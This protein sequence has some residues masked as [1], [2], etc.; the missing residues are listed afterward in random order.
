MWTIDIGGS[1]YPVN[2]NHISTELNG[3]EEAFF[4][5]ENN[6]IRRSLVDQDKDVTIKF[7]GKQ[8][9][10]GTLAAVEYTERNLKCK[11]Y[12][13]VYNLM[14]KKEHTQTYADPGT[15][16]NTILGN[17]CGEVAG[18]SAGSSPADVVA[19]RYSRTGCLDAA[20]YLTQT[21]VKDFWSSGGDTFNIGTRG[22]NKG[23][24]VILS[25]SRRTINRAKKRSI[26]YVRGQDE[27]GNAIEGTYGAGTY[28]VSFTER[29]ATNVATL[30]NIAE[31]KYNQLNKDSSGVKLTSPIE[32]AYDLHPGDTVV[33]DKPELNLSGSYRIWRI[34][35]KA[36]V[37]EIEIDKQEELLER[38]LERQR[39]LEDVGIYPAPG[40]NLDLP[41]GAPA[42]PT[43]LTASNDV[44]LS[45]D[46]DW[47][48]NTETD[49]SQ[50][51][52][53]R[54]SVDSS[55]GSAL[56]AK[57]NS[58]SYYDPIAA[59]NLNSYIYYWLKSE[60][61][62][63][64]VSASCSSVASGKAV[65]L[66]TGAQLSNSI[67][68]TLK[69]AASAVNNS[70]LAVDSIYG[71]V[72]KASAITWN[73][74]GGDAIGTIHISAQSIVSEKIAAS[75]IQ[76]VH[77]QANAIV[78]Y[79]IAANAVI[80][81]KIKASA[82]T[83]SK[84]DAEAVTSAKI[85]AGQIFA[86]DFRTDY[87]VGVG[88][89]GGR[90]F[91]SGLYFWSGG[92]KTVYIEAENGK[93]Y[94]GEG[95]LI[96]DENGMSLEGEKLLFRKD[97]GTQIGSILGTG[98]PGGY[99][100]FNF[101][102]L[103]Y[104]YLIAVEGWEFRSLGEDQIYRAGSTKSHRFNRNIRVSENVFADDFYG[105]NLGKPGTTLRYFTPI[106]VIGSRPT[107]ASG[108]AGL[109]WQTRASAG[110]KTYTWQC[111]Q[112]ANNNYGWMQTGVSS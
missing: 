37:A 64:N 83:T 34:N 13:K 94:A 112:K 58:T 38:Y 59:S 14:N 91:A 36:T 57:I 2:F 62:V 108:V 102:A 89:D 85:T 92:N 84:L 1:V 30:N 98:L 107:A 104:G 106:S 28:V 63:G 96:V 78:A 60:D 6:I 73:M 31:Y 35:K 9:F 77:I 66:A 110:S 22:S 109:I 103:S 65:P 41:A 44:P 71:A 45:I 39:E 72:V 55:D 16:A 20:K 23:K 11:V 52:I 93:L 87:N 33:I 24:I 54:N 81:A 3:H 74:I 19:V 21:V 12:N 100:Q 27:D 46:L 56:L 105:D 86:K 42:T 82:I 99:G 43:G 50:Y 68:S 17:I 10:F 8:V 67:I 90:F 97:G 4:S 26:V 51:H 53:Y 47:S 29:K 76:A 95:K 15:A 40:G 79:T 75:E 18:V 49:L 69:I 25:I 70:R 32:Y 111:V 48:E 7:L 80:A 61:F 88:V 101:N 5:I